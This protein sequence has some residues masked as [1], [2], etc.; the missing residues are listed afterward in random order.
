[1]GDAADRVLR[2]PSFRQAAAVV[3][4]QLRELGGAVRTA[5]LLAGML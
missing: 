1:M 3:G 5:D 2:D 4:A